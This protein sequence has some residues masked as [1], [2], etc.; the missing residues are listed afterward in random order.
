MK[1]LTIHLSYVTTRLE[2]SRGAD[3]G[4][5]LPVKVMD[6]E[7]SILAEGTVS[8]NQ[9]TELRLPESSTHA[10]VRLTWPSGRTQT[11]RVM[12]E[13]RGVLELRFGDEFLTTNDWSAWALP[14]LNPATPL[15][16]ARKDK[17]LNLRLHRFNK[18]WLRLWRRIE[19]SWERRPLNPIATYRSDAAWQL[20]L[21]LE[22]TAWLLQLGGSNV[23]W[24]FISL[25]GGGPARV[26]ITPSDSNDPRSD[27]LKVIVTSF[28]DDAEML[29]EFLA[30][31]AIRATDSIAMSRSLARPLITKKLDDPISAVASAYY[32]LRR[33]EWA[34]LPTAWFAMLNHQFP[35][36]P[37]T[38][39]LHCVRLLREGGHHNEPMSPFSLFLLSL[40]KG[41]PVYEEGITLLLEAAAF[42]REISLNA[43]EATHLVQAL[44]A[45][46]SWTGAAA[47]FYGRKPDVPM[48]GHWI[49]GPNT[50]RRR[51]SNPETKSPLYNEFTPRRKIL[52]AKKPRMVE[53]NASKTEIIRLAIDED[54]FFL[55]N[56]ER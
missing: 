20:D 13:N 26:L 52:E 36:L 2:R 17:E 9:P 10:F 56:I 43:A 44:G 50:P 31:D 55:G 30:R 45:A 11:Q 16:M 47:S 51:N 5:L 27:P 54:E 42:L 28:R 21:E 38:S 29:L 12:L 48:P 8:V 49:G 35:W 46:R 18:V 15:A 40:Q 1:L 24:R 4:L 7:G 32:V 41:W 33:G 53:E 19:G 6:D 14:R 37:D 23:P 34:S 3:G 22:K 39:I 25:P